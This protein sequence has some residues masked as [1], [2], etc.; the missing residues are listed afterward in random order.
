MALAAA[1]GCLVWEP[2]KTGSEVSYSLR[3]VV[4]LQPIVLFLFV[5]YSNTLTSVSNS[6][7]LLDIV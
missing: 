5:P 7:I 1:S 6:S 4:V 2:M 3:N